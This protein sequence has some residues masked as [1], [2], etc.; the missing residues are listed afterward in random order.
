MLE[1]SNVIFNESLLAKTVNGALYAQTQEV[2]YLDPS[3]G[4]M[5]VSETLQLNVTNGTPPYTWE[6]TD[7]TVASIDNDGLLTANKSGIVRVVVSDAADASGMSGIIRISNVRLAI[8]DAYATAGS[9]I[10]VPVEIRQFNDGATIS[11]FQ[12]I[13]DFD[14]SALKAMTI[15]N[16][17]TMSTGWSLS[18]DNFGNCI[19][20]AAAGTAG[21]HAPG[22]F[23]SIRFQVNGTLTE[24]YSSVISFNRMLLNEGDPSVLA[25][26]GSVLIVATPAEPYLIAPDDGAENLPPDIEFSWYESAQAEIYN[27]QISNDYSFS[28]LSFQDSLITGTARLLTGL[29]DGWYYWRVSASNTAGTSAWS[30]VRSFSVNTQVINPPAEPT[31]ISPE[32]GTFNLP[33]DVEFSWGISQGADSYYLEIA[34]DNSFT[35]LIYQDTQITETTRFVNGFGEGL[36]FWRISASNAAGTSAW[37]N[38]WSFSV[39]LAMKISELSNLPD[40]FKLSQNYPNPFN[41]ATT[42]RYE[43]PKLANVTLTVYNMAGQVVEQLVNQKQQPG[44]YSVNWNASKYSSGIYY[45]QIRT[46]EFQQVKKMLLIK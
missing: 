42:I 44:S 22:M 32:D 10:D 33:V 3:E 19:S 29:T 11:A 13:I 34:T 9:I 39:S 28:E 37:S 23:F 27:L 7:P 41:P 43:I 35:S 25:I 2:L 14:S 30:S 1:F 16:T 36:Y 5:I 38:I 8:A 24:G 26:P 4:G 20:I 40:A 31:L 18:Q 17:G 6:V 46:E 15:I 45:Y 12:T 21:I